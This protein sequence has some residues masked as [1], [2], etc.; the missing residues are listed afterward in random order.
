[1]KP[2]SGERRAVSPVIAIVLLV[3]ITTVLAAV[4]YVTV[5]SMVGSVEVT[6]YVY[7][8]VESSN[9]TE[10]AIKVTGIESEHSLLEYMAVLIVNGSRDD[11]STMKPLSPGTVGNITYIDLADDKLSIG[12]E[13]EVVTEPGRNYQLAVIFIQNGNRAGYVEWK[14]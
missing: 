6:P 10:A 5:S 12:D 13:F 9:S 14:T 7:M 11:F 8:T 4:V 1:M 2:I 3:A